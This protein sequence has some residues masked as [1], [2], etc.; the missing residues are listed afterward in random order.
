MSV[1][2][3]GGGGFSKKPGQQQSITSFLSSKPISVSPGDYTPLSSSSLTTKTKTSNNKP[4]A[5]VKPVLKGIDIPPSSTIDLTHDTDPNMLMFSDD[6]DDFE[7]AVQAMDD[8]KEN[9]VQQ[10]TSKQER[11]VKNRL[12]FGGSRKKS[13]AEVVD[14]L[15]DIFGTVSPV[16]AKKRSSVCSAWSRNNRGDDPRSGEGFEE[17]TATQKTRVASIHEMLVN[18]YSLDDESEDDNTPLVRQIS[19]E[20]GAYEDDVISLTMDLEE[21]SAPLENLQVA[22]I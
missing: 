10:K 22:L 13:G 21:Y 9:T 19:S 7:E 4:V 16:S 8:N 6:E 20:S 18:D 17:L 15:D 11:L 2:K 1:R 12:S 14:D 3:S 5:T